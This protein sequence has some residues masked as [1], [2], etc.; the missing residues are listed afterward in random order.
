[1]TASH[2]RAIVFD[3]VGTLIHP[4]PSAAQAYAAIGARHGT[5]L[6]TEEIRCRFAAA[7]DDQERIDRANAWTTSE[8][9]ER[10]RWRDIVAQVLDDV[11]DVAACFTD[12]YEH[13]ARPNAWSCTPGI[14]ELLTHLR[15]SEHAIALASNYDHRLRTVVGGLPALSSVT[16]LVIS[17]E[18][19]WRKPAPAFFARLAD[20]MQ[21]PPSHI[22]F[23]GDDRVNDY[24]A[25]RASGMSAVLLDP[26][27]CHLGCSN[28]ITSLSELDPL[29][30]TRWPP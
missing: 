26:K 21:L 8:E 25:A 13:F 22:L 29:T 7:F 12:L 2:Y 27:N 20:V 23:V 9:R 18:M 4:T 16:T 24:E 28:R 17:S 30:S 1:M 15:R 11:V 6:T 3:A 5:R 14:E 19:G 10:R